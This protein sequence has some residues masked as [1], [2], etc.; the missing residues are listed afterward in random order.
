MGEPVDLKLT[1]FK[2]A[3]D[4]ALS[5]YLNEIEC[6]ATRTTDSVDPQVIPAIV[7][8]LRILR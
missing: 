5:V 4:V 3:V 6:P 1:T 7:C 8:H 2:V